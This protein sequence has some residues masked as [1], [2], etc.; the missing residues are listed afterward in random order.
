MQSK[1]ISSSAAVVILIAFFFMPWIT[2]SCSGTSVSVT[3]Y[4][5]ASGNVNTD[6]NTNSYA[7]D[8]DGDAVVYLIPL[9]AG[10]VLLVFVLRNSR[11]ITRGIAASL[12]YLLGIVGIA[13][14]GIEYLSL[15][16]EL[17]DARNQG[18]LVDLQ[19]EL[20]WWITLLAL[21]AILF[22]GYLASNERDPQDFSP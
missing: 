20:G 9:A 11:I 5:I 7:Q 17:T 21:G 10:A 22:S 1:G 19:Y 18:V 13:A 6:L 8:Y 15:Q 12:Y 14:Q 4:E 3:G 2:V 16:N